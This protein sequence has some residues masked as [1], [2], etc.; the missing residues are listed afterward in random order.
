MA[1]EYKPVFTRDMA[2]KLAVAVREDNDLADTEFS[3][4]IRS[5]SYGELKLKYGQEVADNRRFYSQERRETNR[6]DNIDR[7]LGDKV[8]DTAIAIPAGFVNTVGSMASAALGAAGKVDEILLGSR[9]VSDYAVDYAKTTDGIVKA[10]KSF[11]SQ[12]LKDMQSV[13]QT[14]A[15]LDAQDNLDQYDKD[16][17]GREGNFTD[18][19]AWFGRGSINNLS[20]IGSNSAIAGDV[21]AEGLGSLGPS[22]KLAGYASKLVTGSASYKAA[23]IAN[24]IIPTTGNRIIAAGAK[25][26]NRGAIA[27]AVG[28]SEASGVYSQTVNE[29]LGMS[30]EDLR[31]TSPEY[32]R[33][34][35]VDKL[36]SEEAKS[37][38]AADAGL[39]AF[40]T[41]FPIAAGLGIVAG[42]FEATP[43]KVFQ[44]SGLKGF[45]TIGTQALEEGGQGLAGQYAT[46]TAIRDTDI[47]ASRGSM[48]GG[49]EAFATGIVAG[50]GMAGVMA[51]PSVVRGTP[52]TI[53]DVVT[54]ETAKKV[55][56]STASG[57]ASGLDAA[58]VLATAAANTK[59]GK[60]TVS[61][62]K[63][64][65]N[66]ASEVV[67]P[68]VEATVEKI[69]EFND[70][71]DRKSQSDII[72]TLASI[73]QL[74]SDELSTRSDANQIDD[75][76]VGFTKTPSTSTVSDAF[77]NTTPDK[78]TT[79]DKI[80]AIASKLG[81][82]GV[83][84][85]KLSDADILYAANEISQLENSIPNLPSN[86][87]K[88][89]K[90]VMESQDF[91]KIRLRASQI[92]LNQS[93]DASKPI[94]ESV[95]QETKAVASTNPVNVNPDVV[96][97]ILSQ[98]DRTDLT[99][100]D[101]KI[102]KTAK[103]ISQAILS[104]ASAYVTLKK[105]QN[106]QLSVL[107][108]YK[109]GNKKLPLIE[110]V[111]R[112]IAIGTGNTKSPSVADFA[113]TIIQGL[114]SKDQ[115]TINADG[116]IVPLKDTT[117]R[118]TNF[119]RHMINK[120]AAFNISY[121]QKSDK[122]VGTPQVFENLGSNGKMRP[123]RLEDNSTTVSPVTYQSHTPGG[124]SVARAVHA[125][126]EATVEVYNA[127]AE[128]FPESFPEGKL[129]VS[130]LR[131]FETKLK[132]TQNLIESDVET[133]TTTQTGGNP[134][135]VS[136]ETGVQV[137][138]RTPENTYDGMHSKFEKGFQPTNTKVSYT[139]GK[140]ILALVSEVKGNENYVEF[141][142]LHL[143]NL[144]DRANERLATMKTNKSDTQ[145]IKDRI[146][147]GE[148]TTQ[149]RRNK[150]TILVD[151]TT[152]EYHTDLLSTAAVA[153]LDWLSGVRS[154][155]PQS[156]A[157]TLEDM[158]L[159]YSMVTEENIK[160]IMFSV[161][162][163][164]VAEGLSKDIVRIWGVK[165]NKDTPMIDARGAIE[166]MVKELL[167]SL[168]DLNTGL[169]ETKTVP[170]FNTELQKIVSQSV[171]NV[172]PMMEMQKTIGMEGQL[173]VK[174]LLTPELNNMPSIGAP[175]QH[176]DKTQS[177]GDIK[178]SS[179]ERTSLRNIQN[180]GHGLAESF[181]NMISL[182]GL[183]ALAPYLGKKDF[184][185]LHAQHPLRASIVGKN[186]SIDRDFAE[187]MS[188]VDSIKNAGFTINGKLPEVFYRVGISRVGRHQFKGI[189]PQNNKILR[190]L[191]T[192]TKSTLDMTTKN[193]KDA[194]WLTVAQGADISGFNK[195][196]NQ[197]HSYILANIQ[198]VFTEKYG[199]A[200]K[201][202]VDGIKSGEL[203][204]TDLIKAMG[205]TGEMQQLSAVFAVAQLQIA[206]E[207]GTQDSFETTLSFEL[208]GK[209]DGPGN[210]M[211]NFGQGVLTSQDYMNFKRVGF[212]LGLS[213]MTL[214]KF[215]GE[216]SQLDLYEL[217]ANKGQEALY[218]AISRD[219]NH[220][221]ERLH[222]IARFAT[223][224]GDL[225]VVNDSYVMTRNTAKSPMTKTVYG[226]T[227]R[228]VGQGLASDM[229]IEMYKQLIENPDGI[230][231]YPGGH[232][233]F[234]KDFE[235]AFDTSYPNVNWNNSYLDKKSVDNFTK[236]VTSTLGNVLSSTAKEVI[237]DE[238]TKVN[239]TLVL[240]TAFQTEFM[241]AKFNQLLDE[242]VQ[243]RVSQGKI[244]V[245]KNRLN[246]DGSTR[247][248][249]PDR[250]SLTQHDYDE[251][252]A[253]IREYSPIYA[254]GIQTL[255]I[256][257]MS[258]RDSGIR[259]SSS[260][261][262]SFEMG[263]SMVSPQLSGVKVIPYIT[264][265]NGDAMM[266]NNIYGGNNAPKG[267]LTVFDG[268]DMPIDK[269]AEYAQQI[270]KA[271]L[272]NWEA[273][274]FASIVKDIE[275]FLEKTSNDGELLTAAWQRALAA[276]QKKKTTATAKT[277]ETI[278]ADIMEMH[279]LNQARKTVFKR[280]GVS[281]DHMGGSST[282]FVRSTDGREYTLNEINNMI[283]QELGLSQN[284]DTVTINPDGSIDG[285]ATEVNT[286]TLQIGDGT[287]RTPVKG[288]F[289]TLV[290]TD[291]ETIIN[292]LLRETR[293]PLIAHTV[294]VLKKAD[295][296]TRIVIGSAQE[297]GDWY[298]M[299][300]GEMKDGLAQNSVAR[301][302]FEN[303]SLL[304]QDFSAQ[305]DVGIDAWELNKNAND[306]KKI[307]AFVIN[308]SK[309]ELI[310][311]A[312]H[313]GISVNE[314]NDIFIEL[315]QSSDKTWPFESLKEFREAVINDPRQD[316]LFGA[317]SNTFKVTK[318][319][320]YD[321]LNDVMLITDNNHETLVHE[322]IHAATFQTILDH[323]NAGDK[324]TGVIKD[325]IVRLESL[326][327]EFMDMDFSNSAQAVQDAVNSAK[328][329]IL[330]YQVNSD[331]FSK[332]AALNE[333]M[334][335]SLSNE[336]LMKELSQRPTTFM[337]RMSKIV[338]AMM[339][340]L[341]GAI[342]SDMF[343]NIQFNTEL[344]I[345]PELVND[346]YEDDGSS[347]PPDTNDDG[348]LT[349]AAHNFT[350]FWI[351]LIKQRIVESYTPEGIVNRKPAQISNY[352]LKAQ[353]ALDTLSFE[354]FSFTPYQQETFKAIHMVLALEMHLDP[355]SSAALNGVYNHVTDNLTPE[356]FGDVN[357]EVRYSAVMEAL[358]A[359][360][361]D[362]G[363]SDAIA[364][365]LA[366]SQTS[367]GFR[368]AIEQLPIPKSVQGVSTESLNDF[369]GSIA[370]M[371]MTKAVGSIDTANQSVSKTLDQISESIIL[372]E[373][374]REF[375]ILSGLMENMN[376][377]DAF[378]NG[379]FKKLAEYTEEKNKE[380]RKS[381]RSDLTKLTMSFVTATTAFLDQDR[382]EKQATVI[383]EYMYM[384]SRLDSLVF[385]R[386]F[387]SELIGTNALNK[388]VVALLDKAT[389]SASSVRQKFREE[390]PVIL[391]DAFDT[392]P[393]ESQWRSSHKIMGRTDFS[394]IY[395]RQNPDQ[396]FEMIKD[397]NIIDSNIK[398]I[399][400]ALNANLSKSVA[401]TI[402][403]K[404]QQLAN[405]MNGEGA[406]H[407][408]WRNAYA[409][410][411][412]SGDYT[413]KLTT[414]ID[415]LIS[416]YALKGSDPEMRKDIYSMYENDP[417]A[418]Q[419]L[420]IILQGLNKEEDSKLV[421][422]SVRLNGYKG[423][424]PDHG[425]D[426]A[427][428]IIARDDRRSSLEKRGYKRIA[429]A[430]TDKKFS[431]INRGYYVSN[432]KQTGTYSQGVMQMI[433]DT[434]RGVDATT[435]LTVNGYTSGVISG[436]SVVSITDA[437]NKMT[438]GIIDNKEALLPSYDED[439][440][441][442]Y[443]RY[444]NPDILET[445]TRPK[446]NLALMLGAWAG[447]QVEEKTGQ[448][449]N[450]ILIDELKRIHDIREKG[451]DGLFVNLP[452][453]AMKMVNWNNASKAQ[454]K[455][456]TKPDQIYVDS[457]NVISPQ[458]K[459]H[460]EQVF[461][462]GNFYVRKDQMNLALGYRDPSVIDLWTGNTRLPAAVQ[463]GVQAITNVFMGKQAMRNLAAVEGGIQ[464]VVSTAKDV[465]V[466]RSLVIPYMNTQANVVQLSTRGVPIKEQF[467]GYK[468]KLA[469]IEQ[470][471]INS[472]KIIEID[473]R[474][475]L[476]DT[477]KNKVRILEGQ[478]QVIQ[479]QNAR[480][481]IAPLIK[482]GAYKNISEGL[483]EM[484]VDITS[485]RIGEWVD[486]KINKLPNSVQTIA[487]YGLL[488]KDTAIYRGANKA[489]QYG[490]FIAKSIYYDHLL[491][492]GLS[493]ED[494][495]KSVNEEFVNYSVL[496]GRMR[497][498]NE[499]IG[500]TWFLTFK[501][502]IAK[503]AMNQIRENP[504]RSLILAATI[505]DQG[506]PQADNLVSTIVDE[507]LG[508]SMGWG[509]LLNAG[510][511]NPWVNLSD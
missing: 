401:S 272:Q 67:T 45:R 352:R 359:S 458:T 362:E 288:E 421:S 99:T 59:A 315:F 491:K 375:R 117:E 114:Q 354:G 109:D 268:I 135:G 435:G 283:R 372:E 70:R 174:K 165:L 222:A 300:Y 378:L 290:V 55:V 204:G 331:A 394:A 385:V 36:T 146:L 451:D 369:L 393:N 384:G 8:T 26:V 16:T 328:A 257:S 77:K 475:Q 113:S 166:G 39:E 226:S 179:V 429:D 483:T 28:V 424:I 127:L 442:H 155:N 79:I 432:T 479:D 410:N 97:K 355:Q 484:D 346:I 357:P 316:D 126:A 68:V 223:A 349:P 265:G 266:M 157:G 18:A 422:N 333:F 350:N 411:L 277:P 213:D 93:Q 237:G 233:R 398:Q 98:D 118:F 24:A 450:E 133:E 427:S 396:S 195:V 482:A 216:G 199:D 220:G 35:D 434:Y 197:K 12:D 478:R 130:G 5:F 121:D 47:D 289:S 414:E 4:D 468:S 50:A 473:I 326:M 454:R 404:S 380:V 96:T 206:I 76:L 271:V 255:D 128:A 141:V 324:S 334:S 14:E 363:V 154:S 500:A 294:R 325:S 337:A 51:A 335:W 502:R 263:S 425:R 91:V 58:S 32:V 474:I 448:V 148:D 389:Y 361:N 338:K 307:E 229:L 86:I 230:S 153:V 95:V 461:G 365:L 136:G 308:S 194:F 15:A 471:N 415:Q 107:P 27:A 10:A 508:Y 25:A 351:D 392:H 485:G 267:T 444:I 235:L 430:P 402:M 256:S 150:N 243:L 108:E 163:R 505:A 62:A 178:L 276:A 63:A 477:D 13:T 92:D 193:H 356:M 82:K 187:A 89:V 249:T 203:I 17:E 400:G 170:Y 440:I 305:N 180:Q 275:G 258:A 371:L 366:L 295:I 9:A 164:D 467:K 390:L 61:G 436:A 192:P 264:Q 239:D 219:N 152:G 323:Y 100:S 228:G 160:D 302:L 426:N 446:S 299:N 273:D 48:L 511:L 453:E 40:K 260:M 56:S 506:S 388:N 218:N 391:Q 278:V 52:K 292:G 72:T 246:P 282:A 144:M 188:I 122:G 279:R 431:T 234:V 318:K 19:L 184:S 158:N 183:E 342:K 44:N 2:R 287:K 54:S 488:S 42:K 493:S 374:D 171:F 38:L 481:S 456:L 172:F 341:L 462:E 406:G 177:R 433:Q 6:I 34:M 327:E 232:E 138:E 11:Q 345:D 428:V 162:P 320:L 142:N 510:G 317:P 420:V 22:A 455:K 507:K 247:K 343:S 397:E 49:P 212:F 83:R 1:E 125:D 441:I 280:I 309:D 409:I 284:P 501:I 23:A 311:L 419:N 88:E 270:N 486:A 217:T 147:D 224:F 102:M 387:M 306:V 321:P 437:L 254:N 214:N 381:N 252:V 313:T 207:N 240:M 123:G 286:D 348:D 190:P 344:L 71:P 497:Q 74:S 191:V 231:K 151:Q 386:E 322:L 403:K 499:G 175:S 498:Y 225:M 137:T 78:A 383:S 33:L 301:A 293:N 405:F 211:A 167:E 116:L 129:S 417:I 176:V 85:N 464:G 367:K 459:K 492:S 407:Q 37:T 236:I 221:K 449:Y 340:R 159:T 438:K 131:G 143:Q 304:L 168:L 291:G 110:A 29:V 439:G 241:T 480:F 274:V 408:L 353:K 134:T 382:A 112:D 30:D 7:D 94:T 496:P 347:I 490:D 509:M 298:Q 41:A 64:A 90:K 358:G 376:K 173:A 253:Q 20:R 370:G 81:E 377:A 472:K 103:R 262:G 487:K 379:T 416:L 251:V 75:A 104:R 470:F 303:V 53:K 105:E 202:M 364:V 336:S 189:N 310:A 368:A 182:I 297:V 198:R 329:Q 447:R 124:I 465:I 69:S 120:V 205:G 399:E 245:T 469:E 46:N 106:V 423:Y 201:L 73:S 452:D 238:I 84:I 269:I 209:T 200:V 181:S 21:I 495:M 339:Q 119:A 60:A 43:F 281:V 412:K 132:T 185:H 312:K 460:I 494:A 314:L 503:I 463:E 443:E 186:L 413:P 101:I 80:G 476:A 242:M 145:T 373:S 244:G 115:T 57:V 208:D 248:G 330:G 395:D 285:T 466:V 31:N 111:S 87:Q 149:F 169:I 418:M 360:K 215:Y 259:L 210:M 65:A 161:S 457:W 504:V 156:L 250:A 140:D 196:E 66:K 139:N 319:G 227:E 296:K 261:S 3:G 489:V 332:A 445:H